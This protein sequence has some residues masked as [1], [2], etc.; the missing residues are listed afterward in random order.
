[1]AEKT[2]VEELGDFEFF[3]KMIKFFGAKRAAEIFGYA[4]VMGASHK[5]LPSELVAVLVGVGFSK[6]GVYRAMADIKRF[7]MKMEQERGRTMPMSEVFA[8]IS[9]TGASHRRE[10]V[11]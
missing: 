7:A 10:V 3:K 4:V 6:S 9:A 8:E 5:E 1:M 11:I 2:A